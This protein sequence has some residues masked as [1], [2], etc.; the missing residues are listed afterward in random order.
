M[1]DRYVPELDSFEW[2]EDERNAVNAALAHDD[3]W[4]DDAAELREVQEQLRSVKRRIQDFHLKRQGSTC[5]YCRTNLLGGGPFMTDREH[6]LPK[7]RFRSLTYTIS[8]LSV[9]CKRCNLQFKKNRIDFVVDHE[10][11][12]A[13]HDQSDQYLFA[14]P[15]FDYLDELIERL[16]TQVNRKVAVT[17]KVSNQLK[18]HFTYEYFNLKEL[19]IDSFQESQGGRSLDEVEQ[20][21]RIMLNHELQAHRA[22]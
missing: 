10:S 8:N 13:K 6:V 15:N 17:Y 20:E 4:D 5:C 22:R 7:S 21:V 12:E 11:V 14:H 18:A 9:S 19:E 2:S 16:S 3:P 1:A